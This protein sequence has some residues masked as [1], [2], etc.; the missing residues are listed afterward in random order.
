MTW[1]KKAI[2]VPRPAGREKTALEIVGAAI[3]Q[4]VRRN[5]TPE[6]VVGV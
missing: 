1:R 2:S 6:A 4:R 3:Q 5:V